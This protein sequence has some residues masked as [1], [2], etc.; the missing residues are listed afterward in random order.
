[1]TSSPVDVPWTIESL[2]G[3]DRPA[4]DVRLAQFIAADSRRPFDLTDPHSSAARSLSVSTMS[5]N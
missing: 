4:Q 3:L 5:T 2:V 1:M